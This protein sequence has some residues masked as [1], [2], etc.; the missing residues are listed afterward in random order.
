MAIDVGILF[1]LAAAALHGYLQGLVRGV[2]SFAS[3]VLSILLAA[4]AC[5]D[6]ARWFMSNSHASTPVTVLCFFLILGASWGA[7]LGGQKLLAL[8]LDRYEQDWLDQFLGGVAGLG[9]GLALVWLSLAAVVAVFPP[10][11][12]AISVSAAAT[13]LL[14][15][16]GR[17]HDQPD[18]SVLESELQVDSCD[19]KCAVALRGQMRQYGSG[20]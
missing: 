4:Q 15:V 18:E 12:K 7:L 8:V 6:L 16:S 5:D 9:R 2:A 17:P 13:R 10:A 20:N 1:L 11:Y 3:I 19:L 14:E